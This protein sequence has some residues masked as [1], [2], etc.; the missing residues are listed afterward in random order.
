MK[1]II[2]SQHTLII[3]RK[4]EKVKSVDHNIWSCYGPD[5]YTSELTST[6]NSDLGQECKVCKPL[7]SSAKC[8]HCL[9]S[10]SFFLVLCNQ[11][12]TWREMGQYLRALG[13]LSE[14]LRLV[15]STDDSLQSIV[16]I[17]LGLQDN[18]WHLSITGIH[19]IHSTF[20]LSE[21]HT[22]RHSDTWT[23][24]YTHKHTH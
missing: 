2:L 3:K 5:W 13:V 12:I 16:Y 21:T 22:H 24:T 15:L 18:L 23:H 20:M 1:P 6:G 11:W 19:V 10:A 4:H 17:I 9:L 8:T 7:K 14:E